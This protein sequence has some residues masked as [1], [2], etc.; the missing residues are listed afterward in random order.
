M[1][2]ILIV[3]HDPLLCSTLGE[4]LEKKGHV[5]ISAHT[6]KNG[7]ERAIA[8]QC[9]VILLTVRMTDGDGLSALGHFKA[10][11]SNPEVIVIT[12]DG[13]PEDAESAIRNGAWDYIIIQASADALMLSVDRALAYRRENQPS[14]P[15]DTLRRERIVG[16]GPNMKACLTLLGQAAVSDAN[17]LIAGETGTGKELFARAIHSNSPRANKQTGNIPFDGVNPRA[18]KNFVVVDCTVMPETLV[19]SILF[20]HEKGAFTSADKMQ[21][22][23]V[24]Q[25]DGGTLFLDEIG[26]LPLSIQKNLLRVLQEKTY[27]P[28]GSKRE[29]VSNFRLIAATN[30][31]LDFMAGNGKFRSDLLFRLRSIVIDLPPLRSRPEDIRQLALH[32]MS[33]LCKIYNIEEKKFAPDVLDVFDA[34]AWPGNVRELVNTI[35]GMLAIAQQSATLYIKHVP[36]HI[37]IKKALESFPDQPEQHAVPVKE[38]ES[39]SAD[40]F[41]TFK[42]FKSSTEKR[43]LEDLMQVTHRDIQKA[44]ELSGISRSRLYELLAKHEV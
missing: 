40:A 16:D 27:R 18:D 24:S 39:A 12:D 19:E 20:G 8:E 10:M 6:L 38:Q 14:A 34:Y 33:R 7:L 35:D 30:R 32:H 31:D 3:N 17:V 42:A 5:V 36:L 28:V 43:Y 13:N 1:G 22:G 26:E 2:T 11:L 37:R 23:L 15:Q 9:D 41:P 4:R 29:Q 44:C 21:E 25:A